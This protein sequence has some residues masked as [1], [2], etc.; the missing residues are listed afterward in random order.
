MILWG[1][2]IRHACKF[3]CDIYTIFICVVVY[4]VQYGHPYVLHISWL[5]AYTFIMGHKTCYHDHHMYVNVDFLLL[6]FLFLNLIHACVSVMIDVM[7]W[8]YIEIN[9]MCN[10]Y[11]NNNN[12]NNNNNN[13]NNAVA[14]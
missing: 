5:L 10:L 13:N 6:I 4:I 2:T 7:L 12:D 1:T 8:P 14:I 9:S 3:A 11:N